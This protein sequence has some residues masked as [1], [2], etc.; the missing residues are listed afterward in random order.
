M[1]ANNNYHKTIFASNLRTVNLATGLPKGYAGA[2]ASY[3]SSFIT[4]GGMCCGSGS[5]SVGGG[6]VDGGD[7]HNNSLLIN[8]YPTHFSITIILT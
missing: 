6:P 5:G 8:Q 1:F 2:G 4:Y 3:G 7:T